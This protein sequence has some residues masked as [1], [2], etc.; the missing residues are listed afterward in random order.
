MK[1]LVSILLAPFYAAIFVFQAGASCL[2]IVVG[3]LL[4]A[5]SAVMF[6]VVLALILFPVILLL[7]IAL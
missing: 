2:S 3:I 1:S 7:L 4:V 6:L 5:A